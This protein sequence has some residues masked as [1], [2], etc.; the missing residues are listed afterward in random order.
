MLWRPDNGDYG[1]D[2]ADFNPFYG[3]TNFVARQIMRKNFPIQRGGLPTD[4]PGSLTILRSDAKILTKKIYASGKTIAA[5]LPYE[6]SGYAVDVPTLDKLAEVVRALQHRW[7]TCLVLGAIKNGVDANRM[8]RCCVGADATLIDVP[9]YTAVFDVDGLKAPND[10]PL[11]DLQ[12][13]ANV[14][15]RKLGAPFRDVAMIAIATASHLVS[16]AVRMQSCSAALTPT[17]DRANQ[18][19][20]D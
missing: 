17:D 4:D 8:R 5:G 14:V 18:I 15:R 10:F 19:L 11:T 16:Q 3:R 1:C 6:Y 9:R 12:A 20:D 2:E 13:C 7:D